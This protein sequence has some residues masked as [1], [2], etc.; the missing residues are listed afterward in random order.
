MAAA[1]RTYERC[2]DQM[3]AVPG[4]RGVAFRMPCCDS[5]NTPSPRFYA[6]IFNRVT[7]G[8][9]FLEIDSS[10]F[11]I[12]TANDPEL[13]RELVVDGQSQEIFRRYLPFESYVVTIED[14]P[15]PYVIG[16][17]CWEFP[18]VVPSDWSA[19]HVQQPDNPRTVADLKRAIDAAVVKQGTF[20]LVFHPHK[21]I[22]AEQI[23]ELIDYAVDK[24]GPKVKFL[25]FREAAERLNKNLL[26]GNPLRAAN[27]RD[28]GVRLL[29]ANADGYMDVAIGNE[30]TRCTR[31][32]SPEEKK[33]IDSEFPLAVVSRD[34]AGEAVDAGV[35]FGVV[36]DDGRPSV[37]DGCQ[38]AWH[39]ADGKW[40]N[41]ASLVEGLQFDGRP[42]AV[43]LLDLDG[44]G[45][46]ELLVC[47]DER[48]AVF[49]RDTG[50]SW[51]KLP[52]TLPAGTT[53]ADDRDT[54][55][56]FVDVDQDGRLDVISSNERGY[57]AHLFVSNDEGW[58]RELARGQP[59]DPQAIPMIARD[60]ENRGAWIH[61]RTLWV[62]NE[63][64]AALPDLVDRMPLD[65]LLTGVLFPG[66]KSPEQSLAITHVRPG[67]QVEL[68]AS[69]PLIEDPISIAWG[70]DGKL[71]VAEMGDYPR[72]VDGHGGRGGRVRF[73]EDTDGDGRYDRSTL[74]IEGLGF[75][76]GVT[77]WRKGVIISCAPDILYAED[78]DGDGRA[79]RREVL[80]SG[81]LEGNP[82]HRM[83]G[84]KWGMDG[85]L[86]GAHGDSVGGKIKLAKRNEFVNANNRDFRIRPDEGLLDP[87][88]GESQY[89]RNRDDWGN[90]F[91]N[92]NSDPLYQFVLD[93]YYL[94]RNDKVAAADS[95]VDVPEQAGAAEV[96]P[97][98]RTIARYNDLYA[99]NRFTSANSSM[100]YRDDLLGPAFAGNA[101][102]SEP[103]HNLVHREVLRPEGLVF[104]SRRAA[105]ERDSEF[106]ASADNWFRPTSLATGPDGALWVAD[107]YRQTIEHPQWIPQA[108]QDQIDL[109][110]GSDMGRIYRVYP[111]GCTPRAIP[112][113]DKLS[114]AELVAALDSPSGWQRDMVQQLLVW[115]DDKSALGPLGKLAAESERPVCRAQA[116]WTLELLGG[117]QS[118]Q[119][120]LAL[121]DPHPGVRRHAVRIAEGHLADAP[122]LGEAILALSRRSRSAR[123]IAACLFAGG[124]ERSP[125]RRG[126]GDASRAFSG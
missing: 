103:V 107:M 67:F 104:R 116:L 81:F 63:D 42:Q 17:L 31:I 117:A 89:G 37:F 40:A 110:A 66:P 65:D 88:T 5:Q 21:W 15:Y 14:Y 109:R 24:Y 52:F 19:Q 69:E 79:D 85:W 45:T 86:Y 112:R 90:W 49:R 73:L 11:N 101:F 2:V 60:G 100:I 3:A 91:G 20:T 46:C 114:I 54:G 50:A 115:R 64:T 124:V 13:P 23:I 72:G 4:S 125:G 71:W 76:N 126:L 119:I 62:Q 26:A 33:W 43:R 56:R 96:F 118:Q 16:K 30:T 105:D 97:R 53:L 120:V 78:T 18:C 47:D 111:V 121:R 92:A 41:D 106:L 55:L 38:R 27:G 8:G 12:I 82:Q 9:N 108:I 70:P 36:H 122:E 68:V 74:F 29:D 59:G 83:N 123:A 48:Q 102:I 87:Q 39:F 44:D 94:R 61:S 95:R 28:R 99:A 10:V 1:R 75:P 58:S 22:K 98:S 80:Y 93:D 25:N 35:R 34:A 84:F 32:W 113:L 57:S 77:P 6:E 7:P 51:R